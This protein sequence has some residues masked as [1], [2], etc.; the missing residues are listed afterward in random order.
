MTKYEK[1]Q[2]KGMNG[3]DLSVI[4]CNRNRKKTKTKPGMRGLSGFLM[5]DKRRVENKKI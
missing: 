4:K 5:R 1:R 2:R 3:Q